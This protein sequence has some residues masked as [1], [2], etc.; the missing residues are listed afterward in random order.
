[1]NTVKI[2]RSTL[3]FGFALTITAVLG[4]GAL[5]VSAELSITQRNRAFSAREMTVAPGTVLRIANEDEFPHQ[6]SA[7]GPGVNLQSDLQEAG[8]VIALFLPTAGT[9]EV[10]CGIHPRMR[11]TVQ[12]R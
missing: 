7:M 10:R 9:V 4:A 12:V 11:L 2:F 5:A 1:M 8:Q 3:T 6:I